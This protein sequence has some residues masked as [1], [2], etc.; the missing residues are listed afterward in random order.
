MA[1]SGEG[2]GLE[3]LQWWH[4]DPPRL[5]VPVAFLDYHAAV[6]TVVPRMP[7]TGEYQW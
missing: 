6:V 1:W 5:K 3:R 4:S 2:P 7:E